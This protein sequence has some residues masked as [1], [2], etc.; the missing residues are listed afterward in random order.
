M[1]PGGSGNALFAT[2]MDISD[3]PM[4][5]ESAVITIIKGKTKLLDIMSI[6]RDNKTDKIYSFIGVSW[7]FVSDVDINSESLR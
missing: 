3:K 2:L 1:L 4:I 5:V 6:E 7:A